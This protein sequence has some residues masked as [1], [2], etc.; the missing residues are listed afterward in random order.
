[1]TR[2]VLYA[3]RQSRS[4]TYAAAT[5]DAPGQSVDEYSSRLQKFVPAEVLSF[6]LL[7]NSLPGVTSSWRWI[8]LAAG[9][10]GTP[11]YLYIRAPKSPHAKTPQVYFYPLACIA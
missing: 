8:F 4:T 6:F 2:T 3:S 1:M 9:L 7:A 10:F 11:L 5:E